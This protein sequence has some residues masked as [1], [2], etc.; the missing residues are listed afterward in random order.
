ML[1]FGLGFGVKGQGCSPE[2]SLLSW[3]GLSWWW[4][5]GTVRTKAWSLVPPM[6]CRLGQRLSDLHFWSTLPLQCLL[7]APCLDGCPRW[8]LWE[9]TLS[10]NTCVEEAHWEG[11]LA[12]SPMAE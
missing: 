3:G 5:E 1:L 9:Q 11:V 4:W 8:L 6:E 12:S 10:Q 2:T 7:W